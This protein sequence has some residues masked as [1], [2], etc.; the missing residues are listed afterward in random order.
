MSDLYETD[1]AAWSATQAGLLRNRA[2]NA[3]DWDHVA[4]EIEGLAKSDQ[5]EIRNRL[6][7]LCEHLLKWQSQPEKQSNSWRNSIIDAREG[8]ADL[9][10]ESPSLA[11]H[12]AKRLAWAY[13][14]A[15]RKAE[16]D[17]GLLNLPAECPWPIDAM[18]NSEFWPQ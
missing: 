13:A 7:V 10:E 12:P 11:D 1:F 9:I 5:R 6:V 18:L 2:H 4:E 14:R 15:R 17:T 8:I 3:I 16:D